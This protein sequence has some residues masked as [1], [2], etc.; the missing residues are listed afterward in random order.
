MVINPLQIAAY[1]K[2]GVR[3]V[4]NHRID[5]VWIADI[6][7]IANLSPSSRE[8]PVLLSART[9]PIPFLAFGKDWRLQA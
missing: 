7:R 4:K 8:I 2:S 1:R 6:A 3:K 9:Q 5:A